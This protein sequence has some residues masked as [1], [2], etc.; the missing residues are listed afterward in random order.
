[1]RAAES[2]NQSTPLARIPLEFRHGSAF[3]RVRVNDSKPLAFKLDTGFGVTTIH[4]DLVES[5]GL[6][7]VGTL[8]ITG[9]AGKEEADWLSGAAFEFGD[10]IIH[11]ILG[12]C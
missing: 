8:T 12:T 10:D 6:K 2:T 1:M 9:I 11:P 4:P 3:V 5:L 7:R